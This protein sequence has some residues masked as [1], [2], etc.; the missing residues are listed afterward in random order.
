[1]DDNGQNIA[2]GPHAFSRFLA[3]LGD[4]AAHIELSQHLHELGQRLGREADAQ[5]TKVKAE[6]TLK[7]KLEY[8]PR[9]VVS[10]AYEIQRKVPAPRR[11]KSVLWLTS[12][13]NLTPNNPK[14]QNLQFREVKGGRDDAR[15]VGETNEQREA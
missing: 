6:L 8:E 7:V 13:G 5:G 1:M 11:P 14:Q 9:G 12:G 15:D 2:E 3:L 10:A 4:G